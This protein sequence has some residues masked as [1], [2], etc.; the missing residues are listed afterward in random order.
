METIYTLGE[1][2]NTTK[3]LKFKSNFRLY[4]YYTFKLISLKAVGRLL[5]SV[6]N[7]Y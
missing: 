4:F 5:K 2:I 7:K 1:E 3:I 6:Y